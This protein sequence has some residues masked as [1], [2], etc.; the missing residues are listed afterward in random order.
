MIR[1]NKY[2]ITSTH[3]DKQ[4]DVMAKSALDSMLP[5]L[6]GERKPRLGLEHIRTF[7]PFGAIIN[8]EIFKGQDEHYYLTAEMVYFDKQEIITLSDGTKLL[9]EF[10]SV[11]EYPFIEC[12]DKEVS[13]LSIA[14]DHA[15][16]HH[17]VS[18]IFADGNPNKTFNLIGKDVF[19]AISAGSILSIYYS[20]EPNDVDRQLQTTTAW[21]SMLP[22]TEAVIL[23]EDG[24]VEV[25]LTQEA[26]DLIQTQDGF[27][28]VGHGYYVDRVTLK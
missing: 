27:L 2:V 17:Y 12:A 13:K 22:G 23:N 15:K 25:V 16:G 4:G 14:T 19:A 24:V 18:W 3:L 20:I 6:N 21:W 26:L 9:K 8:G 10:F 28:C 11:G 7:P 1:R 5:F